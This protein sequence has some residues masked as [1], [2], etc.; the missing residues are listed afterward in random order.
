MSNQILTATVREVL[1]KKVKNLRAQ[2]QTP[3]VV[4]GNGVKTLHLTVDTKGFTKLLNEAGTSSL[5]DLQVEGMKPV[6]VLIADYQHDPM[7]DMLIHADLHQVKLDE[8][9][10][11]DIALNFVGEA[12]AVK[13]LG[14][15]LVTTRDAIEVEAFP[16]DLVSELD[17]DISSLVTFDDKITVA[18]ITVPA[19]I[20]V[21]TDA[22]EPVAV[23]TAPRS[24]EE[25]EAE[26][27][28]TTSDA[29]AAAVAAT[30]EA[31]EKKPEGDEEAAE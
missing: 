24:D 31:S 13:D 16:Q 18:D 20:T 14:G 6:K 27:A 11:T 10:Q 3:V 30:A 8:K 15:N 5:V 1:G 7:T 28:E 29:E 19:T 17:V 9:I 23:V 26:L 2:G 22:E 4:Y 12:P 21:L 25:L